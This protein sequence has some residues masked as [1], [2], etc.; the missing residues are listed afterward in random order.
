M[1]A[2]VLDVALDAVFETRARA[3]L[4]SMAFRELT[5]EKLSRDSGL[6]HADDMPDLLK[7]AFILSLLFTNS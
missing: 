3:A 7:L 1:G 5:R 2:A 6:I 4:L